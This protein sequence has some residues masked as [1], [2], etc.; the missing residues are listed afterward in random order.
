[1]KNEILKYATLI[2]FILFIKDSCK[3]QDIHFSQFSETPILR[4]PALAGIFSGD[5]RIQTVYRN[6]WNS[7]TVPYQTSSINAEYKLPVG[8]GDDFITIGGAILYDKAG[9]ISLTATHVLP[10]LN[11]HKSLSAE[12]N[13]YLS[14]GFSAG[15]VQRSLDYS[16]ITT[17]SQFNGTNYDPSLGNGESFNNNNF[18]Y[19]D[20]SAGLSFNTQIGENPDNNIYFGA[21]YHH[22]NKSANISFYNSPDVGIIPKIV[23]SAGLRMSVNDYAYTTYYADYS[24]Q[25]SSRELIGGVLYSL[26][27]DDPIA[28]HYVISGGGF[29]RWKDAF[30]PVVKLEVVP[31]T[32]ALSYDVNVSSLK[33]AS[34]SRGGF[35]LS[36]SYQKFLDRDNSSREAVRCPRF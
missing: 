36:I 21:A 31:L 16:K 35:E 17:N 1:M 27:L 29:L 34:Q 33:T 9:T 22:F 6:Q 32:F 14:A 23:L 10:V 26:K 19:F 20:G 8:H 7:V 13:M 12:R 11:F 2:A 15:I 5:L 4:N 30:I 25:G 24:S 3:A 18:L 28:P